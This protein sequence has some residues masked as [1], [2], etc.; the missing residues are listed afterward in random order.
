[1]AA[2]APEP[3]VGVFDAKTHLSALLERVALGETI[4]ITRHG[5]PVAKLSPV[6]E[7]PDIERR[8]SAIEAIIRLSKGNTLGDISLRELI[9]EGRE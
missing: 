3:E 2:L 1:M 5:R 6:A 8:R 7:P 9:N 4:T